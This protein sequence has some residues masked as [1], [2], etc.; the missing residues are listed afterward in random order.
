M[1]YRHQADLVRSAC[2]S[3]QKYRIDT[4][5]LIFIIFIIVIFI[6]VIFPLMCGSKNAPNGDQAVNP[7]T[8]PK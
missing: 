7:A 5:Y 1:R 2:N 4:K 3:D 6:V 8:I